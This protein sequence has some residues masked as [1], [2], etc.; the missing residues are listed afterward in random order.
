MRCALTWCGGSRPASLPWKLTRRRAMRK[1]E[2]MPISV[3]EYLGQR[4]D[5]DTPTIIPSA[6]NPTLVPTCPFMGKPCSKLGG[7]VWYHPICSVRENGVVF[8]VCPDR[9]IPARAQSLTPS[10]VAVLANVAQVLFPGVEVEHVGYRRQVGVSL[11]EANKN[12]VILD[13]VLRVSDHSSFDAGPRQVILEVQGGGET[14]NTGTI[15][16]HVAEW[17]AQSPRTNAHLRRPLTGVGAIRNN[18][19]KRQLEQMLRKAPLADRFSG[20]VALVMGEYLYKYVRGSVPVGG[21][22][23]SDWHIALL[24]VGEGTTRTPGAVPLDVVTDAVF[25]TFAEFV[26]AIQDYP[27]PATMRNPFAGIYRT[28][29]NQEFDAL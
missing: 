14:S 18:A 23:R 28:L 21:P 27:L 24:S 17:A 29:T 9:L 12:R 19:W 25:M 15:T 1:W 16:R 10:H 20:A 22:F 3:A 26:A 11:G 8:V 6:L 2:R 13:Y 5:V 7:K 4:T